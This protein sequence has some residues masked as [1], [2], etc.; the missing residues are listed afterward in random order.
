MGKTRGS[1]SKRPQIEEEPQQEE[2]DNLSKTYKAKFLVLTHEEGAR[3]TKIRFRDILEC[4]YIPTSLLNDVGMLKSFTQL[5][6]QCGL[7]KFVN[8][9]ENTYVDLITEFYTTLNVNAKNSQILE[10]RLEGKQ[11]QLTYSFMNRVFGFKRDGLCEYPPAYKSSEFWKTLTGLHTPFDPKKGKAMFIKDLKYWLMHKVLAC[12]IFHKIES[13]RVSSQELFLLWCI[14]NKKQVCWTYWI[15]NQ[16]LAC[17]PRKDGPLTH[18]HVV[19]IIAKALNVNLANYTRVVEHSYFTKHA[20]VRGEV[21]DANFR[22][23]PA[24]SRSCWRGI[25]RPPQDDPDEEEEQEESQEPHEEDAE[26]EEELPQSTPFG[27]VPM[28]TYPVQSVPGSSSDHPPIWDQILH[29]Q[30]EMQ[31]Q[32]NRLNR[33]Q[34][35]M[36]RRQR[37]MEYKLN[38]YFIRTGFSVESPPTTPTDD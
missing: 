28:L 20:F 14:H 1:T 16:L 31:G 38:Q 2:D 37:K 17:A 7:L 5:L 4:K 19:T 11:H 10:F 6:T 8:M 9:H 26:S 24:R 21:V 12:V 25:Q 32:L 34:Q 15:F 36:N 18:G 22:V 13:N 29:N 33:H 3:L 35:E 23:V 27:D 30:I